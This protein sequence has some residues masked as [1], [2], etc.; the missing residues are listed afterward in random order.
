MPTCE[1]IVPE[2]T[3]PIRSVVQ[4]DEHGNA[5]KDENG[6]VIKEIV[7]ETTPA[8]PCEAE[9]TMLAR[10]MREIVTAETTR[11]DGSTVQMLAWERVGDVLYC[12]TCFVPGT[13]AHLSGLV[14][15]HPA[16]AVS[17]A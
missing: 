6:E 11:E 15:Q 14:T 7:T 8:H 17:D 9:A 16:M 1:G 4:V 10:S 3:Y 12:A 13:M 2:R 5:V